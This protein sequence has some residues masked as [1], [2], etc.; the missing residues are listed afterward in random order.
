[1]ARFN[2]I[3]IIG[4][5]LIGGSIGLAVRKRGL[6]KEVVGIFRHSSTMRRALRHK[7][8]DTGTMDIAQ[9]VKGAD[10]VIICSPVHAIP[11]LARQA[12]RFVK[13][14]AVITDVGSTK[15]WIV[16]RMEK[17]LAK[18]PA[19]FVGSHP[20]AG[21]ER[22]GVEFARADLFDGSPCIVTKTART[23]SR[24]LAKVAGFWKALGARTRTMAPG[25]HDRMVA[26]I[27]HLPHVVAFSLAG[28][29][30][31]R[32][33]D[34]AAEGFRDTTRIASSDPELWADIFMTNR[35]QILK[36]ARLFR[37][38]YDAV[39]SS[40]SR[41]DRR[42]MTRAMASARRKRRILLHRVY[43]KKD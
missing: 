34:Y 31:E 21:S 8:I 32:S 40:I 6:A 12:A 10:M 25:E 15:S 30:P 4:V 16:G 5:G 43:G 39:V 33:L 17:L 38:Y 41:G 20:M 9:G 37:R 42:S 24:A 7:A 19:M 3:A 36:S 27:S 22:T 29:V 2:R 35:G 28:A 26:L 18:S 23:G 14:G 11:A 1:M 13:A